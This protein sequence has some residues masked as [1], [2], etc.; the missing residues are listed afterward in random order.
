MTD[1]QTPATEAGRRLVAALAEIGVR[2]PERGIVAAIEAESFAMGLAEAGHRLS[3]A[4]FHDA[5]CPEPDDLCTCG[6]DN[7]IDGSGS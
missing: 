6:I 3:V 5:L 7:A 1:P 2:D 4:G